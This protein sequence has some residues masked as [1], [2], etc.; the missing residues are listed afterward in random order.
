MR[1]VRLG[2]GTGRN[3][4][5][6]QVDGRGILYW[7]TQRERCAIM[8]LI[9]HRCLS[10]S[11]SMAYTWSRISLTSAGDRCRWWS[12]TPAFRSPGGSRRRNQTGDCQTGEFIADNMDFPPHSEKGLDPLGEDY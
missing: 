4:A 2:R 3:F 10:G 11:E 1:E 6:L 5:L 7:E 8:D 12:P 9:A